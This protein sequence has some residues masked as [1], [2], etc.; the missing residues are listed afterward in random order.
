MTRLERYE[1]VNACETFEQLADVILS[2]CDAD[3]NIL[4]RRYQ[5]DG[6]RMAENC[7]NF[8]ELP[9]PNPLTR[10]FGIRQQAMYIDY[11]TNK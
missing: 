9:R 2:F 10:E 1:K 11:Y 7:R 5:F 4:G 6:K 8:K 3:G